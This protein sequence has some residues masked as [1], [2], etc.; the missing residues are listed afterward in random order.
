MNVTGPSHRTRGLTLIETLA[1]LVLLSLL[2]AAT[3]PLVAAMSRDLHTTS[4]ANAPLQPTPPLLEAAVRRELTPD[5]I[6]SL[7][8]GLPVELMLHPV[9]PVQPDDR[10]ELAPPLRTR[11][12]PLDVERRHPVG[13]DER[14]VTILLHTDQGRSLIFLTPDSETTNGDRSPTR[15]EP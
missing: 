7:T 11:L 14:L 5:H 6:R 12:R 4:S 13:A 2:A 8:G 15:G 9:Q 10:H 1:A 3:V